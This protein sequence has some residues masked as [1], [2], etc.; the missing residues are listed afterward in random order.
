MKYCW[1]EILFQAERKQ[2]W[3]HEDM[4]VFGMCEGLFTKLKIDVL[5][6]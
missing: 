1:R 6:N 3:R 5:L 4:K 2:A